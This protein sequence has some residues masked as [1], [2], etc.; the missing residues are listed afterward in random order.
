MNSLPKK[1]KILG[2]TYN[3]LYFKNMLEVD[4]D[5]K[6]EFWGH[7]SQLTKQIRIYDNGDYFTMWHSLWHEVGHVITTLFHLDDS[8]VE[9]DNNEKLM[10]LKAKY[11][12]KMV[13]AF[14]LCI[15]NV[16]FD[17][18]LEFNKK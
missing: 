17:N 12:E 14:A 10:S 4:P 5:G 9:E 18:K 8:E 2:Y 6:E 13:D 15:V 1:L 16:C 11:I 3:I 7:V